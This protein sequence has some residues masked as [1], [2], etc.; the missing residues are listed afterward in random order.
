MNYRLILL[1]IGNVIRIEAALMLLP[2]AVSFIY[3]SGDYAPFLWSI[4]IL[5]IVGTLLAS[6]KSKEKNFRTKD[7]FIAVAFSWLGLSLFG[8]LPFC[9]SGCFPRIID[10]FFE[11]ISGFSA[12][13]ATILTEIESLPRAILFWRSFTHWI[14]GMGVLLF[15]MAVMP[16]MNA[17]SVN[18]LRSETTGP[19]PGKIVPKI[20]ET[21]RILYIIYFAMTGLLVILLCVVGLPIFDS[22]VTSFSTAGTGG[23]TVLNSSIAG[24]NNVA[25]EI[26][27]TI[28]MFLFGISFSLYFLLLGRKFMKFFTDGE[29]KA[30]ACFFVGAIAIITINT[31]SSGVYKSISDALRYS[32]FQVSSIMT[33]TG[34]SIEDHNL[35]PTLSQSILVVLMF[36]GSCGGST[37]GGIKVVRVLILFKAAKNEIV[38][39]FHP[40]AIR[41]ISLNKKSIS[42]ELVSKTAA[43]FFIHFAIL[44]IAIIVLSI[45]GKDFITTTTSAVASLNNIGPGLGIV[46]PAGNYSSYSVISKVVLSFCMMAGRLEFFPILALF[47]STA[48]KKA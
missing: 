2:L 35:W 21:A 1:L 3:G 4:P 23:F 36:I 12:T 38:K 47:T 6:I 8:A 30:Y 31:F 26:I 7:A 24:Y 16:S 20:R 14:G 29:L 42:G 13:G 45:E 48:W 11:S 22:L 10:C 19:M 43:Y 25:A 27:I 15:I 41:P 9:F 39:V 37:G 46:G 28:F 5:A 40:E 44:G 18:L 34:F 32:S 33:T 17:S